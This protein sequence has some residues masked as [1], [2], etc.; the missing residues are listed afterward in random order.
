MPAS[1]PRKRWEHLPARNARTSFY[2]ARSR[3]DKTERTATI[4]AEEPRRGGFDVARGDLMILMSFFATVLLRLYEPGI[5]HG[6]FERF[7]AL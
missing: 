1:I 7:L 2:P 3:G 4:E 5:R 6:L